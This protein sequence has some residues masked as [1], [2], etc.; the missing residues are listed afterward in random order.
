MCF[1]IS[2]QASPKELKEEFDADFPDA[3]DFQAQEKVNGFE[4]PNIPVICNSHP[5]QISLG[6]WGLLPDWASDLSHRKHT[7]NARI[8]TL[9]ETAS[10]KNYIQNRCIIPIKGFYEW[11][12]L[13]SR[14]NYKQPYFIGLKDEPIS[15]LAGI[16]S[17]YDHQL[18]LSVL[19][20]EANRL[21]AE[22]HNIKKRMPVVLDSHSRTAWLD[23][24]NYQDFAYPNYNP[25]L[26][27]QKLAIANEQLRLF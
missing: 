5:Q 1:Y 7:L 19:T 22:I 11:Q 2:T 15:A 14:G 4:H 20:T 6:K 24:E 9:E 8:E 16:Y 17:I 18:T 3:G 25:D 23:G 26:I 27:A 12:W 21:M 10:F 13:D